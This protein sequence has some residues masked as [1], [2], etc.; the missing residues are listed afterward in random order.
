MR[1][2]SANRPHDTVLAT[3][4]NKLGKI[5]YSGGGGD[6]VLGITTNSF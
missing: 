3:N 2:P 6:S 4:F 5:N 1:Q